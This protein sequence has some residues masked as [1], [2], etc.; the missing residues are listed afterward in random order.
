MRRPTRIFVTAASVLAIAASLLAT[1][2]GIASAAPMAMLPSHPAASRP[3]SHLHPA[4]APRPVATAR[5]PPT[6]P[7]PRCCGAAKALQPCH[8]PRLPTCLRLSC[9]AGATMTPLA[10]FRPSWPS[11]GPLS[12]MMSPTPT[13]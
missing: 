6:T 2:P 4:R 13:G 8:W 5:R 11:C 12:L 10:S 3:S 7:T 1:T 9:I